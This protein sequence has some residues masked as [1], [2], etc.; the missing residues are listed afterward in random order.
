M[1]NVTITKNFRTCIQIGFN[2]RFN[3]WCW[4]NFFINKLVNSLPNFDKFGV[5]FHYI[6]N[7]Y[8]SYMDNNYQQYMWLNNWTI[9]NN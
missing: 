2:I 7:I 3:I 9:F 6:S 5:L 8:N 4:T 1:I